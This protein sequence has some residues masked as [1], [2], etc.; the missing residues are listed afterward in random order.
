MSHVDLIDELNNYSGM[1]S[2]MEAAMLCV[3]RED[4]HLTEDVIGGY[5]N[6]MEFIADGIA[7]T[8]RELHA[9]SREERRANMEAKR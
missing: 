3:A 1:V 9:R 2:F 7:A 4:A 8:S 5:F 6:V